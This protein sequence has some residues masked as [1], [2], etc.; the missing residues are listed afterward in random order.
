MK[1]QVTDVEM[2]LIRISPKNYRKT[3]DESSINELAE[4]IRQFGLINPITVRPVGI[5]DY[6]DEET[7]EIISTGDGYE[8]VCGE[9][10]FRACKLLYDE[11]CKAN[12]IL[13]ARKK[14]KLDK[15][16]TIPCVIREMGD[17][18]A[19]D[20]MMT[21]NLMREDVDPF[22]ESY[23]FVEMIKQGKSIEDLALKFGKSVSFIR[24]RLVL[25]E[26]IDEIKQMVQGDKLS[27][28]VAMYVSRFTKEQQADALKRGIISEGVAEKSVR[29]SF[30]WNL[31]KK[32]NR[33]VFG[34][35]EDVDGY[36]KC[37]MCPSNSACQGK[38]FDEDVEEP[39]CMDIN[40]F[41]RKTMDAII[42]KAKES[43]VVLVYRDNMP[44]KEMLDKLGAIGKKVY[45]FWKN[46][47][48]WW[49]NQK[50]MISNYIKEAD[51]QQALLLWREKN[52][53]ALRDEPDKYERV[54]LIQDYS[55][56]KFEEFVAVKTSC[57]ED[58]C[59]T[60]GAAAKGQMKD[61]RVVVLEE[62]DKKNR[63]KMNE[64]IIKDLRE[65]IENER[66]EDSTKPLSDVEK[67][68]LPALLFLEC[69]YHQQENM[70]V[71]A[72][73]VS[74]TNMLEREFSDEDVNKLIRGFILSKVTESGVTY[75]K[76]KQ[77]CLKAVMKDVN[78]LGYDVCVEKYET[79]YNRRKETINKQLKEISNEVQS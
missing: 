46:Y 12:E 6:L 26:L 67:R 9:R 40:C 32:L 42:K 8:I 47:R 20:A 60:A 14:K 39:S 31:Q 57:E 1:L 43:D 7:G 64:N 50:P 79:V 37:S 75:N 10:R 17:E 52:E 11:E 61:A 13:S 4:N 51:Y 16:R 15:Y 3:I 59:K 65:R 56:L 24:K 78:K 72:T 44:N 27:L 19:F 77:E 62:K 71:K 36:K 5:L 66:Y 28:S 2:S 21:E 49:E 25:N 23:A 73:E 70:G 53:E 58:G 54:A 22:E 18:E 41:S 55:E 30:E 69:G 29:S 48:F 45:D 74:G 76:T 33:A 34:V 35:D 68:V 38:L 63:D